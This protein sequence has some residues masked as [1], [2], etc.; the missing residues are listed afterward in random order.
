MYLDH[1]GLPINLAVLL[2]DAKDE[3]RVAVCHIYVVGLTVNNDSLSSWCYRAANIVNL[4]S[5]MSERIFDSCVFQILDTK[6]LACCS[7]GV[8][9][10]LSLKE[11]LAAR[12][13]QYL[14]SRGLWPHGCG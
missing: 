2:V 5:I 1:A 11:H 9:P 10:S 4:C 6:P 12:L 7:L 14:L 3:L 13:P 8:C